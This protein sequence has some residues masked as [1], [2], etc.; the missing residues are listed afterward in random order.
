MEQRFKFRPAK[1]VLYTVITD[2]AQLNG[3]HPVRDYLDG[4]QWDGIKRID[5]WL[6]TYGEAEDTEYTSAV[7]TLMPEP[8][9]AAYD[10]QDANLTKC[11]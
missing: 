5:T 9:G 7:G 8:G 10:G 11:R 1:D 3:F 6:T 2:T 4:L